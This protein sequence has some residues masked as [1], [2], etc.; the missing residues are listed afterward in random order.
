MYFNVFG[1][2]VAMQLP[3]QGEKNVK[4]GIRYNS[5]GILITIKSNLPKK[6]QDFMNSTSIRFFKLKTCTYMNQ[7]I[8]CGAKIHGQNK[9]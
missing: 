1:H 8:H 3:E 2:F 9:D 4:S 7:Q 6:A 5:K